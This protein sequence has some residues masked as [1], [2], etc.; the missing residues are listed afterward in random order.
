MMDHLIDTDLSHNIN[1]L[2][3]A[4]ASVQLIREVID[5]CWVHDRFSDNRTCPIEAPAWINR[6]FVFYDCIENGED[7]FSNS[8]KMDLS[9]DVVNAHHPSSL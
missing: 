5:T 3:K 1:D 4:L 7:N 8:L 9:K 6:A 2:R